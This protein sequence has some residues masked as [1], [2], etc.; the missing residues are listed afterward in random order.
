VGVWVCKKT[1]RVVCGV[2]SE[3]SGKNRERETERER[4]RQGIEREERDTGR[5]RPNLGCWAGLSE[6]AGGIAR[7]GWGRCA[8]QSSTRRMAQKTSHLTS[9][10][11]CCLE[12]PPW[13]SDGIIASLDAE[14]PIR[15]PKWRA[16]RFHWG[17]PRLFLRLHVLCTL[18]WTT[19]GF[20][21]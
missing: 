11:L 17:R 16:R 9:F 18:L 1:F 21:V 8:H 2:G 19:R 4:E 12:L 6:V 13:S 14:S 15:P 10:S 7:C 5:I 3:E 20:R